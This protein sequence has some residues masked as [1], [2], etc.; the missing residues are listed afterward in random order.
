M[1]VVKTS[2]HDI[3]GDVRVETDPGKGTTFILRIPFTLS[4]LRV[5]VIEQMGIMFA[6]PVNSIQELC[7]FNADEVQTIDNIPMVRWND[8]DIP[9]IEIEKT[10]IYNRAHQKMR[11]SGSP[12]IDK[13]MTLIVG[14]GHSTAALK[15]SRFWNEQESTIRPIDSPLPLPPGIISSV[16]F[17]DAKVI[18]L[19]DPILLIKPTIENQAI[20][21]QIVDA[22]VSN[23]SFPAT[24]TILV[25]DD[26]INVRRYLAL[27]L[28]KAGYQVE[29]A[30]DGQDAVDRLSSGLWVDAVICDIEMPRLDGYGFLEE[31]KGQ[32]QYDSLP[33]CM[34]TSRS[35]E[36][37]R[38]IAMN[39]GATDYFSKPYNEAQLLGRLTELV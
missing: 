26:S 24:K 29:Q 6:I 5:A 11:L 14:D 3:R 4:I 2:L 33:V 35:N 17:G 12:I 18:P 19:I 13:T 37:H 22:Q 8:K 39:L 10:L 32:A 21:A 28:E 31:I 16:V 7:S 30:K 15:I 34:L 1:D 38:K 27:T 20:P 23:Q 9:L 25:V 36:K